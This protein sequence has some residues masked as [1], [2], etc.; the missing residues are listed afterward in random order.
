MC[1]IECNDCSTKSPLIGQVVPIHHP[2]NARNDSMPLI[3]QVV[4]KPL[5]CGRNK[6]PPIR[7]GLPIHHPLNAGNDSK[8][9]VCGQH[10]S[11]LGGL[12]VCRQPNRRGPG[13]GKFERKQTILVKPSKLP[14]Q[15]IS[16][17]QTRSDQKLLRSN[18]SPADTRHGLVMVLLIIVSCG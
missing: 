1:V 16:C 8:P 2:L 5:V 3:R 18:T 11:L 10:P 7:R 12:R 15:T 17:T 9:L 13:V 14:P 6:T 4:P